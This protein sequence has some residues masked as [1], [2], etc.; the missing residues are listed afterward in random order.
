M[1]PEPLHPVNPDTAGQHI[2][3]RIHWLFTVEGLDVWWDPEETN[4]LNYLVVSATT[5]EWFDV[6]PD[7]ATHGGIVE[8]TLRPAAPYIRGHHSLT[9]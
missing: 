7:A 3:D 6:E 4:G 1:N 9:K 5:S 2:L 8:V